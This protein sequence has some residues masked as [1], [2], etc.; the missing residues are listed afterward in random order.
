M[1]LEPITL[2]G[3]DFKSTVYTIPPSAMLNNAVQTGEA[4]FEPATS[5]VT[6]K[7]SNR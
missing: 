2:I 1:G 5:C 6:G 7:H 4:G 3:A